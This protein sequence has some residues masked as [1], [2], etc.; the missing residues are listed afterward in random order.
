MVWVFTLTVV[1]VEA[2]FDAP[3]VDELGCVRNRSISLRA[4]S[5]S[6]GGD[7][8]LEDELPPR[9]QALVEGES[10]CSP[11]LCR[12]IGQAA[13]DRLLQVLGDG[14]PGVVWDQVSG[15][16]IVHLLHPARMEGVEGVLSATQFEEQHP[17]GVEIC[18]HVDVWEAADASQQH[19][20]GRIL[21]GGGAAL[22]VGEA[23]HPERIEAQRRAQIPDLHHRLLCGREDEEV[24]GLQVPVEDVLAVKPAQP[25]HHLESHPLDKLRV[26]QLNG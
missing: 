7:E 10:V 1:A 18:H 13:V 17:E 6:A 19:L 8:V 24:G 2:Q 9:R 5:Y 25:P 14:P 20:R 23:V 15:A 16:G 4:A 22:D 12:L 26:M 21:E 3:S 11:P